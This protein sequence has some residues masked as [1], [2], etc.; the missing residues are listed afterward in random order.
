[1]HPRDQQKSESEAAADSKRTVLAR[2]RCPECAVTCAGYI[3][4]FDY[5]PR[6][7]RG[8]PASGK[9]GFTHFGVPICGAVMVQTERIDP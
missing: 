1:M 7:C 3:D 5:V 6:R 4:P 2:W 9:T 8:V